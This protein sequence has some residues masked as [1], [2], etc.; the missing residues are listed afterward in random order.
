MTG[1]VRHIVRWVSRHP[2]L[3]RALVNTIYRLPGLDMA[4]RRAASQS[5]PSQTVPDVDAAHLSIESRQVFDR[6]RGHTPR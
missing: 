1:L 3:K 4:L 6:I 5:S 2:S